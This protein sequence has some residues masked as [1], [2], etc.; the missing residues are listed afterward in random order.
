MN[1][2]Y[3]P[4]GTLREACLNDGAL[5]EAISLGKQLSELDVKYMPDNNNQTPFALVPAG[6]ELRK[7][8]EFLPELP[9]RKK[10]SLSFKDIESFIA[11]VNEQKEPTTRIFADI[12]QRRI[13][14]IIDYH[15]TKS[16]ETRWLQHVAKL[17]LTITDEFK[18]WS[19]NDNRMME[20]ETFTEFLKD[21]RLDIFEPSNADIL[22]IAQT[23][24]ATCSS[25]CAS[26]TRDNKGYR[27]DFKEDLTT[28]AG[29]D[30]SLI[31][32]EKIQICFPLFLGTEPIE[33]EAD[34]KFRLESGKIKLGYRML[35]VQ[36]I[37]RESIK[38]TLEKIK[39]E[40]ELPV[41]QADISRGLE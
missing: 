30:G 34:F 31:V 2:D 12:D 37:L 26:K 14:A 32:P 39:V 33:I 8:T 27:L 3:L 5:H 19:E 6:T 29:V 36:K 22:E 16:D 15:G 1:N 41:F 10:I 4:D 40:T 9:V 38:G 21:H 18:V 17:M 13:M 25:R 35:G 20:Q 24:E 7:L 23:L 11:Y 28:K